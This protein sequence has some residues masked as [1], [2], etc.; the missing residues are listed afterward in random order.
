MHERPIRQLRSIGLARPPGVFRSTTPPSI[1]S[2]QATTGKAHLLR[3]KLSCGHFPS[4]PS[5]LFCTLAWW[6]A[7]A[8][9]CRLAAVLS[10]FFVFWSVA[11]AKSSASAS[12]WP[13]SGPI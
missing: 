4:D 8:R 5:A 2:R 9:H 13:K 10:I 3:P 12:S 7:M 1:C 11:L 6:S